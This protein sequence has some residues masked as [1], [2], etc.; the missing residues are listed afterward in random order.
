VELPLFKFA[1]TFLR[2]LKETISQCVDEVISNGYY[3][4]EIPF[5]CPVSHYELIVAAIF[6]FDKL[7]HL[8]VA[9]ADDKP[10]GFF[11]IFGGGANDGNRFFSTGV[12]VFFVVMLAK[13]HNHWWVR[14]R[15]EL[16][17]FVEGKLNSNYS[18]FFLNQV[19]L[20]CFFNT[21]LLVNY[22][23]IGSERL[24]FLVWLTEFAFSKE[25]ETQT[26]GLLLGLPGAT[27]SFNRLRNL[28]LGRKKGS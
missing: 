13:G 18:T 22:L 28:F 19:N 11:V 7:D 16:V 9:I 21:L 5:V 17:L 6:R 24:I 3:T 1:L 15:N 23:C 20:S 10:M 8:N 4:G 27:D 12:D 25:M 26:L 14:V 2:I